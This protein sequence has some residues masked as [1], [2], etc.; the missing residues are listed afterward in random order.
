MGVHRG[1]AGCTRQILP[2]AVGNVLAGLGV[3]EALGQTEVDDVYV[4][5][6]L[7][8]ANQEVV[9]L[10]VS[11]QEMARVHKL[12]PLE[13][14]KSIRS[15]PIYYHLVSQHKDSLERE[16]A[17]AVVEEVLKGGAKKIDDHHVV[18]S[19]NA[20]PMNIRDA[21]YIYSNSFLDKVQF[22]VDLS[23]SS[24]S[25][26]LAGTL[27]YL[28]PRECDRALSRRATGGAWFSRVP[29]E[30]GVR[31][32]LWLKFRLTN[33]MATSSFVLMFVPKQSL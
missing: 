31:R 13:L 26:K 22:L 30:K 15:Q 21:D 23:R 33:L 8:N 1:V 29:R 10:D 9:W 18:V 28:H 5:L 27:A 6:L 25:T 11:V 4:V 14:M 16:L 12:D 20:E 19:L 7:A 24:S 17:L 2:V 32:C 3:A